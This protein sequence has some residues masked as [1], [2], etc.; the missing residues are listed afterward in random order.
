MNCS[1]GAGGAWLMH[2]IYCLENNI[3]AESNKDINFHNHQLSENVEGS[4]FHPK[5]DFL[6]SSK[7]KF[8]L[9]LNSVL[10]NKVYHIPDDWYNDTDTYVTQAR[11]YTSKEWEKS[12]QENID[13]D[14]SWTST[15]PMRL[16]N[17]IYSILDEHNITYT[18][19][20]EIMLLKIKEF[21][22]SCPDPFKYIGNLNDKHWQVWCLGLLSV[23]E[24]LVRYDNENQ[25][26]EQIYQNHDY[27]I[28]KT[29]QWSYKL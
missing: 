17:K 25:V 23:K 14:I 27:F 22:D 12:Y 19:N 5:Y 13:V 16:I 4:H 8:N 20:N 2:V 15:D 28:E 26:K 29:K 21:I 11:H 6:L 10:K 1:G 18:K 24:V 9:W 7:Y 3:S